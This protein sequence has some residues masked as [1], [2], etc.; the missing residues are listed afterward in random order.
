[1]RPN[2]YFIKYIRSAGLCPTRQRIGL[3]KL[4]FQ[5]EDR[6]VTAETLY[7]EALSEK[8]SVSLATV[9]NTLHQFRKAGM[10]RE[11]TVDAARSYFDTNTRK[12][13]HFFFEKDGNLRDIPDDMIS[14]GKL[15]AAPEGTK[16][17]SVD[18][19]ITIIDHNNDY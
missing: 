1:M 4:L 3:A 10:L 12:H 17:K 8:M 6:H 2:N 15:P 18:V 13:H 5:G 9:Y 16:I 11:I 7:N 14:V 19:V